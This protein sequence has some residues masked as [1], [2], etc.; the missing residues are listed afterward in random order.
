[1]ICEYLRD[2]REKAA[3][4]NKMTNSKIIRIGT[5]SSELAT[6]QAKTVAAKLQDSGQ[7]TELIFISS[8]GDRDRSTPLWEMG[9]R[10]VFT[11]ALDDALLRNEIDLAVHSYKDLP[12]ANPLPLKVAAVLE[13]GDP[14]DT[15]AAREGTDFL[16]NPDYQAVIAT[17]STRRK[18]Q[19]LNR[20]PHHKIVSLRGNVNTRLKKIEENGWD[21][22]I[23]AAAGL[24]RI[25]LDEH[26]SQY[27]EWMVPAPAQAAIA[28]MVHEDD[29]KLIKQLADSKLNH[30]ETDL[31]TFVERDFLHEMEAG[32]SSPVGA[33]AR[34][35]TGQV[36]LRAVALTTDGSERFDFENARPVG[37]ANDF[38]VDAAKKLLDQ[39]ASKVIERG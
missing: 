18:A 34:V 16:N 24:L 35:E 36:H 22:A 37:E 5:R 33:Y 26:I 39:G 25:N 28:V 11:K 2:L 17:G 4:N 14:R 12:T 7:E 9:G 20:Y 6:W 31:C 23:F 27:L 19:W 13:R 38:G 3:G 10:G 1:M 8:E 32:C 29:K 21:G 30:K 15:L